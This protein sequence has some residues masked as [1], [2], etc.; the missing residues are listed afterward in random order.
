MVFHLYTY[1]SIY[2]LNCTPQVGLSLG[3]THQ[4]NGDMIDRWLL[5]D[6]CRGLWSFLVYIGDYLFT[7]QF[8]RNGRGFWTLLN[9][10][11]RALVPPLASK[12]T[13][14]HLTGQSFRGVQWSTSR[15]I[16]VCPKTTRAAKMTAR[17]CDLQLM[18]WECLGYLEMLGHQTHIPSKV[19]S[20]EERRSP[21]RHIA[22]SHQWPFQ[23]DNII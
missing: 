23:W 14:H 19:G 21:T 15:D 10:W 12:R 2:N 5:V 17:F 16:S 1:T 8:S 4:T 3:F 13:H 22:W 9:C 18:V 6:D 20:I 11:W 7:N